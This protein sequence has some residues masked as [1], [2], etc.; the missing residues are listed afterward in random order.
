MLP[1]ASGPNRAP[2]RIFLASLALLAAVG[3]AG[4]Y[5]GL[6]I[7]RKTAGVPEVVPSPLP[8][9]V[10]TPAAEP[11]PPPATPVPVATP[12]PAAVTPVPRP[13]IQEGAGKAFFRSNVYA[14]LSVD[15]KKRGGVPPAGVRLEPIPAGRHRAVFSVADF[16]TLEKEFD[17]K[18]G[19][20]AD[21]QAEFPARGLL[22]VAVNVEAN[23]AEVLV[24]GKPVGFAPFKKTVAAGTHRVEVRHPG[25]EAAEKEV[26][27]PEDDAVRAPFELRKK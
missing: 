20:T 6:Q 13:A 8:T 19:Q 14:I 1:E 25:F 16:M 21:V 3:T 7:S 4:W 11:T 5:F 9:T 24:D 2:L 27:V 26:F 12:P 17:V 15:G 23:G 10:A 18:G 22:Q